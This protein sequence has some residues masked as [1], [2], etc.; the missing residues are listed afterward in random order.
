MNSRNL[1]NL[2]LLGVVAVL[3]LLVVYEPGIEAPPPPPPT[4]TNLAADSLTRIVIERQGKKTLVLGRDNGTWRMQEPVSAALSDYRINAILKVTSTPSL[5]SF[6]A[7]GRDL[8]AYGLEQPQVRLTLD[9]KV[10]IALGNN[11]ALDNRRYVLVGDTVHLIGDNLYYQLIGAW[12]TYL[13]GHPLAGM[14]PLKQL[15]LPG[16][17]LDKQD[18]HWHVDPEPQGYS[19][20][21]AAELITAWRNANAISVTHQEQG[22]GTPITITPEQGEPLKLLITAQSPGLVLAR[23][24]LGIE[25]HLSGASD[26]LLHLPK[27]EPVKPASEPADQ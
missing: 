1:L 6:P 9:N 24:D 18:G 23:P 26:Q 13:D 10:S 12:P 19:A 22:T 17:T 16:L 4:L 2:G 5:G 15:A 21:Q 11:T 3:I 14:G 20:D 8:A 27:S 25:Y 7:Q